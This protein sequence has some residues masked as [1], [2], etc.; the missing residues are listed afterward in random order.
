M[1]QKSLFLLVATLLLGCNASK[2]LSHNTAE[3]AFYSYQ[4]NLAQ[5]QDDKL[6]VILNIP[7]LEE[8]TA[9]YCFPKIV[10]GIY[11]AMDFG[12]YVQNLKAYD[13]DGN[14]LAVR[15]ADVNCWEIERASEI[16]TITY[17]VDDVFEVFNFNFG[18]TY[19]RSAASTFS[20]STFIINNNCLFGYFRG[21]TD[22]AFQISMDKPSELYAATSLVNTSRRPEQDLF[23]ASS[24]HELVDNPIMYSEPDTAIISLP[25]IN[26]EV[27]CFSSSGRKIA[28][29][30]AKHIEPLLINQTA[31]L[32]N[33]LPVDEYTFIIYHNLN[34]EQNGYMGDGLEHSNST[35][36]L[37]YMPLDIDV[38]KEN[39]YGIASHEFFHILMPLGL[40][41]EE[42]EYYDFNQPEFSKHLWLYEG[43]TEYFT[44]HMPITTGAQSLDEFT[45][46]LERKIRDMETFNTDLSLT[47]LSKQPMEHQDQYYNVYLKGALLNLCLDIKLREL[48]KGSY[49][50]QNLVADLTEQYGKNKPF[51]DD[52]LFSEMV[53]ITGFNELES[54]INHYI[55][56]TTPLPLEE[57]L[58]KVGLRLENGH[59]KTIET[60][61]NQ[62][63]FMR[64]AWINQ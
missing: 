51:K 41:S 35:L 60:L 53:E 40:H 45:G 36:I 48:S 26:V 2:K 14:E 5:L 25:N 17:D 16:S 43:M 29:D 46:I 13:N 61:T 20:D 47:E 32:N 1:F 58:M 6:S 9:T 42:I 28:K 27:A 39:I 37:F 21:Y 44:M 15:K 22:K 24:Y 18:N 31:Y 19:Y 11:G 3:N 34:T 8:N 23:T 59:V 52:Q 30:I 62:Q 38:I 7:G 12:Q 4:T 50:V 64:K 54:F 57:M 33:Q 49:G 10:P 63:Q 55:D 56:G